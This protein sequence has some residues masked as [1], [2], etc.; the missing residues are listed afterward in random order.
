MEG[1]HDP[2]S[3]DTD[4]EGGDTDLV[5]DGQPQ[6]VRVEPAVTRAGDHHA[7]TLDGDVPAVLLR[8]RE[9]DAGEIDHLQ[10]PQRMTPG[11][12]GRRR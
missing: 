10:L 5:Y 9:P 12:H 7:E 2:L 8:R 4:G 3:S 11:Q 1:K 6:F